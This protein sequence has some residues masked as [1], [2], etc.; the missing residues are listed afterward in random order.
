MFRTNY[1]YLIVRVSVQL[2]G[3]RV[4][5]GYTEG[6][7]TKISSSCVTPRKCGIFYPVSPRGL[8]STLALTIPPPPLCGPEHL[9]P[10][11][12]PQ[13]P[14]KLRR[15]LFKANINVYFLQFRSSLL[16]KS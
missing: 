16:L 4:G 13:N 8:R 3:G 10:F 15:F 14:L 11:V 7:E 5:G 2:V 1:I 9:N 12:Q 6:P